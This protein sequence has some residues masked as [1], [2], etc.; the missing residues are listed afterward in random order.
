MSPPPVM[1]S[2]RQVGFGALMAAGLAASGTGRAAAAAGQHDVPIATELA[3]RVTLII[4]RPTQELGITPY[5]ARRRVTVGSGSF[6]GPRI[7]GKVLDGA[8][9]QLQRTDGL[10]WLEAEA[11]LQADDGTHI[12]LRDRGLMNLYQPDREDIYWRTAADFEAPEGP[13]DWLNRSLFI[14]TYEA[15][16][17]EAG[18]L[19]LAFH[20]LV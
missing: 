20:R 19:T 18:A 5:G 12:Y 3:M 10:T 13:H 7:R 4:D 17:G 9:W 16:D 8:D 1:L 15:Y 14:G 2:R 6:E 11:M